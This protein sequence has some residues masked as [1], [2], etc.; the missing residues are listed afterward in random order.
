MATNEVIYQAVPPPAYPPTPGIYF[1]Q[2]MQ[3]ELP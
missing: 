3:K 1:R 2:E